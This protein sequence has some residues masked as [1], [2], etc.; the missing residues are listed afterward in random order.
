MIMD[1]EKTITSVNQRFIDDFM[2]DRAEVIGKPNVSLLNETQTLTRSKKWAIEVEESDVL[3]RSKDRVVK[4]REEKLLDIFG[5]TAGYIQL[6]M[7]IT[8]EY[9]LREEKRETRTGSG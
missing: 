2:I 7:D 6:F 4:I 5:N 8:L 3:L 9:Q 1:R